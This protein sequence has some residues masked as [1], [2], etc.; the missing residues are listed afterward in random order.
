MKK[1]KV[2]IQKENEQLRGAF[3][4][5]RVK[6][7]HLRREFSELLSTENRTLTMWG[8]KAYPT[9]MSW[10][11]IFFRMGELK[12]DAEYSCLLVQLDNLRKE[13]EQLRNSKLEPL[14]G[15]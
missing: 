10:E 8:S 1:L 9:A 14:K 12:S 7:E 15:E 5:S 6:E 3:E 11:E 2:D 13:L 4:A